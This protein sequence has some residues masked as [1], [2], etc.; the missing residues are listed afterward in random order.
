MPPAT[1]ARCLPGQRS[2]FVAIQKKVEHSAVTSTIPIKTTASTFNLNRPILDIQPRNV[3][4]VLLISRH[5]RQPQFQG[6]N[7]DQPIKTLSPDADLTNDPAVAAG[8]VEIEIR[9]FHIRHED[10]DPFPVTLRIL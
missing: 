5:K 9:D 7:A 1:A 10:I 6:L 8:T 2:R 4:E 3:G